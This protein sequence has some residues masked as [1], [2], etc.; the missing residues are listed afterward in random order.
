MPLVLVLMQIIRLSNS[1]WLQRLQSLCIYVPVHCFSRVTVKINWFVQGGL[2]RALA[3]L[4]NFFIWPPQSG[5]FSLTIIFPWLFPDNSLTVNIIPD[6]FQIP[7]HFQVF[8]TS[9]HSVFNYSRECTHT[10]WQVHNDTD[11]SATDPRHWLMT[12]PNGQPL[13]Y[14]SNDDDDDMMTMIQLLTDL[15]N[16]FILLDHI[17]GTVYL[18]CLSLLTFKKYLKT[19]F[20]NLSF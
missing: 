19:F 14:V 10:S 8:Q 5:Q 18:S 16:S 15:Q 1:S 9:G 11:L 7:W 3:S 20:F 17:H 4:E 6:M 2:W 13:G 12:D